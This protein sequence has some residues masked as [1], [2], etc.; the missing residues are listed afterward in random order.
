MSKKIRVWCT[1]GV[2]TCKDADLKFTDQGIIL[3]NPDEDIFIPYGSLQLVRSKKNKG[4]SSNI[5]LREI[6]NR[7]S[8]CV[9]QH[10]L[11]SVYIH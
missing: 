10:I 7:E 5:R 2:L 4:K 6:D 3:E 1:E 11:N 8:N 9:E